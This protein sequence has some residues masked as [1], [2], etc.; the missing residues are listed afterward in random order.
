MSQEKDSEEGMAFAVGIA[1]GFLLGVSVLMLVFGMQDVEGK[2]GQ[3]ICEEQ[4][5]GRLVEYVSY[6]VEKRGVT[7][8]EIIYEDPFD[9][10]STRLIRQGE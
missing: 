10:G 9:G 3:M 7:C 8:K 2:L 6:D 1:I 5:E 4:Y